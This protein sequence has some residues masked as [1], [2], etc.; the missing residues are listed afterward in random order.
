MAR[1]TI[2][3]DARMAEDRWDEPSRG[4]AAG[5]IL[6]RRQM[7]HC[8]DQIGIGGKELADMA[9]FAATRNVLMTGNQKRR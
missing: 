6:I 9:T 1:G 5:T 3:G 4:V 7:V 2:A 8:L